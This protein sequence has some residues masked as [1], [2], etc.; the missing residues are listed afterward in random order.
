M[1]LP[2]LCG[3]SRVM[4]KQ[5]PSLGRASRQPASAPPGCR[6]Q[7]STSDAFTP[8]LHDVSSAPSFFQS[9]KDRSVT[10]RIIAHGGMLRDYG[11]RFH[12][13]RSGLRLRFSLR[14]SSGGGTLRTRRDLQVHTHRTSHAT[15]H[16]P[17]ITRHTPY[18]TRHTP[19]ATRHTYMKTL[20]H[21]TDLTHL[22]THLPALP[23]PISHVSSFWSPEL[24]WRM[25]T[26]TLVS[27]FTLMLFSSRFSLRTDLGEFGLLSLSGHSAST[28]LWEIPLFVLLGVLGG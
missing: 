23:W 12:F 8:M 21:L 17:H 6:S 19:Y 1:S 27:T 20:H 16:T 2:C 11:R 15:H 9:P 28:S 4:H 25:L 18:A 13:H 5:E 3:V 14:G 24:T 10:R 22:P 26:A 7:C